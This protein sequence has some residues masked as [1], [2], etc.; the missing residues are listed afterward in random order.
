MQPGADQELLRKTIL[1][2]AENQIRA[3]DPPEVRKA[4]ERL[5]ADGYQREEAMKFIACV[6]TSEIFDVLK[7][8]RVFYPVGYVK[9]LNRLPTLPWE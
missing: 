4:L 7:Q 2:I 9:A 6:V 1:E 8:Q 3:N 5:M